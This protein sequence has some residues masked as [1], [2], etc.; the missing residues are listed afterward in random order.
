MVEETKKW[1]GSKTIVAAILFT[2]V[3]LA[4]ANEA[5]ALLGIVIPWEVLQAS[6]ASLGLY[7]LRTATKNVE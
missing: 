1:Y 7:G 6:L 3:A 5:G 4:K 2:L